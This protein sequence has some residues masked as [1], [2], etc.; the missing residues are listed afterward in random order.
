MYKGSYKDKTFDPNTKLI[1]ETFDDYE[2][3]RKA[4]IIL[5]GLLG[6]DFISHFANKARSTSTG[7]CVTGSS[8]YNNGNEEKYVGQLKEP[9][10]GYE[11]GR[12]PVSEDFL[13]TVRKQSISTLKRLLRKV[14]S[15]GCFLS[16]KK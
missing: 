1:I 14:M 7:F 13:I 2:E 10:E 16:Q 3:A 6:V 8:W 5:H 15:Q 9:L 11:K 4:E 12:L